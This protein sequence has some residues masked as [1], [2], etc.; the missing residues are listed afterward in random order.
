MR[1]EGLHEKPV[2]SLPVVSLR[3]RAELAAQP[4]ESHAEL[5]AELA[6]ATSV[7]VRY[8]PEPEPLGARIR[9]VA[10]NLQR[11]R[12]LG[13]SAALLERAGADV[14]LLAELDW[15]MARSNQRHTAAELA[16]RLGCGYAYAVEYLELGLGDAEERRLHEGDSNEVGYHGNAIL[17]RAPLER[18]ALL[19]LEVSGGWFDGQRGEQ[20]IGGRMAVLATVAMGG[21]DVVV[22]SVHLE[23]HSDPRER[24]A[25]FRALLDGIEAYLPGAPAL[26]GG[27]LNTFSLGPADIEDPERARQL[28]EDD[29]RR[30][31]HPVPHEPLFALAAGRGYD[32]EACN[33][34]GEPT[35]RL[36]APRPSR[37]GEMKID[38]LLSRGLRAADPE[39]LTAADP[40]GDALSD[41]EPIAASASPSAS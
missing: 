36:T 31:T 5:L 21:R 37:R 13:A 24:A 11:G 6:F 30:L 20:R 39:V 29:P 41:H 2:D 35:Q 26:I 18:P 34:R 9:A 8:P 25:Q 38:W 23:S 19:R 33:V 10:W 17:S 32:W 22:A 12:R 27:D 15:G 14:L 28:F 16:G 4:A 7:E 40:A 1:L 3:R